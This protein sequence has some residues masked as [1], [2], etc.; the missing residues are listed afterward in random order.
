MGTMETHTIHTQMRRR[1]A[2]PSA[3][4][5]PAPGLEW[6]GGRVGGGFQMEGTA[7]S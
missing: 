6:R 5:I 2:E 3:G 7:Y 1:Q 4:T